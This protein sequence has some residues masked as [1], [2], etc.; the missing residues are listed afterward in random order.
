MGTLFTTTALSPI[1]K[2]PR[3]ALEE[4]MSRLQRHDGVY[5]PEVLRVRSSDEE[6]KKKL[7]TAHVRR[8][9]ERTEGTFYGYQSE[10]RESPPRAKETVAREETRTG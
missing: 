3:G 10:S 8:T 5:N 4:N 9:G 2:C 6:G 7:D 1:P